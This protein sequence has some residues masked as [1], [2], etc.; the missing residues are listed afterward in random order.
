MK[1]KLKS[2]LEDNAI[3]NNT[4]NQQSLKEILTQLQI[5]SQELSLDF[6]FAL[7]KSEFEVEIP[8]S[9]CNHSTAFP[10]ANG[11]VFCPSCNDYIVKGKP[12]EYNSNLGD[13][14]WRPNG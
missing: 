6:D 3:S 5:I 9:N 12:T 14:L 10:C 8:V 1:Y 11:S 7:D 2:L 4:T 13:N